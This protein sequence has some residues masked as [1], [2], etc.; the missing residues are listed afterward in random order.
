MKRFGLAHDVALENGVTDDAWLA[1]DSGV[2]NSANVPRSGLRR[3][4]LLY[5]AAAPTPVSLA[6]TV[7]LEQRFNA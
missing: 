2:N 1:D 7:V 6:I 3:L 4:L 5:F